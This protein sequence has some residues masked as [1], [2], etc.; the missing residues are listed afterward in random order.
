MSSTYFIH[1]TVICFALHQMVNPSFEINTSQAKQLFGH[2]PYCLIRS[3][4]VSCESSLQLPC[5]NAPLG[6]G[7]GGAVKNQKQA[8]L[9]T[10]SPLLKVGAP[11]VYALQVPVLHSLGQR[12]VPRHSLPPKVLRTSPNLVIPMQVARET[13]RCMCVFCERICRCGIKE[14]APGKRGEMA[15]GTA[16]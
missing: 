3:P 13:T 15:D 6:G 8:L 2:R 16:L 7:L 11:P 9:P 12:V 4:S 14:F 5:R 1:S 10:L